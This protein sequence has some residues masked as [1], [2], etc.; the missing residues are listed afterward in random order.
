MPAKAENAQTTQSGEA[1]TPKQAG[2]AAT[3]SAFHDK[4]HGTPVQPNAKATAET[5][6]SSNGAGLQAVASA[7][8]GQNSD[9][10]AETG[11]EDNSA[12][13]VAPLNGR[14]K[15]EASP[16]RSLSASSSGSPGAATQVQ[17]HAGHEI[18]AASGMAA[19]TATGP[20]ASAA[21]DKDSPTASP[22]ASAASNAPELP[23]VT[24]AR[25]LQSLSRSEM[26]ISVHSADFG[27]V[28]IHTAYGHEAIS[29]QITLENA[30]LGTALGAHVSSMEQKLG[31]DHGL[32]ASVTVNTQTGGDTPNRGSSEQQSQPNPR[33]SSSAF[34]AGAESSVQSSPLAAAAST[35]AASG[36]TDGSRLDIRI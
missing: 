16:F 6:L 2:T 5:V 31:E 17:A 35:R 1:S 30:Q 23:S 24:N 29:A 14:Q 12:P 3:T 7:S 15:S 32:R 22:A 19:G 10:Q 26:Q 21:N 11:E 8:A 34:G 9:A 4:T 18:L 20:N 28:S 27:R 13:V 33:Y 36:S 25:L